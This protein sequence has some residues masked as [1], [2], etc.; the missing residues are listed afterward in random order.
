[1]VA[2]PVQLRACANREWICGCTLCNTPTISGS[3]RPG[4]DR[5]CTYCRKL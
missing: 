3:E 4:T 5:A 2:N 1:M